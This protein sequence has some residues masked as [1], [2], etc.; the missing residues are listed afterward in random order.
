MK[1][2]TAA[3]MRRIEELAVQAGDSY[4]GLMERA[5]TAA[6]ARIQRIVPAGNAVVV[7]GK[8]NNGG[9]GFVIA[10][11]LAAVRPVTVILAA[12][13]PAT[14]D[15]RRMFAQLPRTVSVLEY[16][17]EPYV[18]HSAVRQA[19]VLVDCLYGIGFR[20]ALPAGIRPLTEQMGLSAAKKFAVDLPS[21][22]SADSPEAAPGTPAADV[23]LTM[24]AEKV[25]C[26]APECGAVEVLDIGIPAAIVTAV[27]G[28]AEPTAPVGAAWIT[29][30]YVRRCIRPRPADSHKGSFGRVLL[31]CGSPGMAGAAMLCARGA[32]RCGAGLVELAVP[33]SLYPVLAPA[34][35]EAVFLLLPE[36]EPGV[37]APEALPR[38]LVAAEKASAVVVGC[39]WGHPENGAEWLRALGRRCTCPLVLDADGINA[40]TPHMLLEDTAS[41]PWILTPHPGEMARLLDTTAGAV[42]KNREEI[43]RR[44]ADTYGVTLALKGYHTLVAAP[45]QP[46]LCNPTGNPGMA[47]G[48]SGD[49]LAG[50]IGSLAAQGL[51]PVEAAACG[52]WLHG[53]AGDAAAARLSQHSMLPSDLVEELGGLFLKFEK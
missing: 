5:G 3:A 43:A 22:V 6:A 24:T 40:I 9:D 47:T 44:F 7:C 35:P 16:A 20:G 34:L 39:G 14:E 15:A 30:E 18:C 13:Q 53:A 31:W 45:E 49:V 28:Q 26:G 51:T 52:V 37:L 50:I 48:G 1:Q 11:A 2:A 23:T 27:L 4:A 38:L 33:A 41:A 10:R 8:G 42:Q 21:G 29:E 19:A 25:G 32:L 36:R 46:L 12:G 17:E